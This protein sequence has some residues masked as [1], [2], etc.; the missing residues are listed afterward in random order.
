[1]IGATQTSGIPM[2]LVDDTYN[3]SVHWV[4]LINIHNYI[5]EVGS[6]IKPIFMVISSCKYH[7]YY[8]NYL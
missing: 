8:L 6:Y 3:Y 2:T 4:L 5:V 1:M 7:H